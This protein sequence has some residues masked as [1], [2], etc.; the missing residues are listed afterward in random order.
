MVALVT[1]PFNWNEPVPSHKNPSTPAVTVGRGFIWIVKLSVTVTGHIPVPVAV[2][3][4]VI[5]PDAL[6]LG[7]I[8]GFKVFSVPGTMIAGPETLHE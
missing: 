1:F 2:K 8:S 5:V 4:T 7:S 6:S 3:V